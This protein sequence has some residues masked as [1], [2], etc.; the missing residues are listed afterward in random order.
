MSFTDNQ[1]WFTI[2]LLLHVFGAIVG[3]GPTFAFAIM[4]PMAGKEAP[5]GG[6][7]LSRAIVKIQKAQVAPVAY[8]LQPLTGAL[9]IFNRSSIRD[10]FWKEEWLVI[11]VVLYAIIMV[12]SHQQVK[13]LRAMIEMMEQE[14]AGTPEFGAAAKGTSMRGPI[15]TVLTM[16]II[17]LMIWKPLSECAGPLM[18]C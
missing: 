15:L 14:K 6:Y 4:G 18:R 7:V 13:S 9:L 16:I 2:L 17:V 10:N 8:V 1:T 5:P 3:L 11:S 12:V